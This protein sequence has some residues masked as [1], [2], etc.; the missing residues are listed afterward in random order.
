MDDGELRMK[1]HGVTRVIVPWFDTEGMKQR[2]LLKLEG[3][4][5]KRTLF[6]G[7]REFCRK[8]FNKKVSDG[9]II[10]NCPIINQNKS[11][12]TMISDPKAIG[13]QF[14]KYIED[15]IA[16]LEAY[17]EETDDNGTPDSESSLPAE[18]GEQVSDLPLPTSD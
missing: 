12:L 8:N 14:P 3:T 15:W 17:D 18:A 11:A 6:R 2:T 9:W 16:R 5:D 7:I 4:I 10:K 13:R 1:Y